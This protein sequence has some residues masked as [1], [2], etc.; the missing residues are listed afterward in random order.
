MR[1]QRAKER[2]LW[3][4][5]IWSTDAYIREWAGRETEDKDADV[6]IVPLQSLHGRWVARVGLAQKGQPVERLREDEDA[7]RDANAGADREMLALP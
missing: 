1:D 4:P 2:R 3:T 7:G 5:G 6:C